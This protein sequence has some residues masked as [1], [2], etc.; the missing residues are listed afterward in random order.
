MLGAP[1][2]L[3]C[4]GRTDAGVHGWGQ[5]VSFDA[6]ADRFD[7]EK[8]QHAVNGLCGPAI[9]VRS[10]EVAEPGFSARFDAKAR[11]Y[12]YTIL[13]RPVP[14]WVAVRW[15]RFQQRYEFTAVPFDTANQVFAVEQEVVNA[16]KLAPLDG[17]DGTV[18]FRL[19]VPIPGMPDQGF[20]SMSVEIEDA[21]NITE[22]AGQLQAALVEE[23]GLDENGNPV[24]I[25]E[26]P[27]GILR[28][29]AKVQGFEL[30]PSQALFLDELAIAG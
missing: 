23:F 28:L 1:I 20:V 4:A 26:F 29:R 24:V 9:V 27:D 19:R 18:N 15:D 8:V 25:V 12:R 13:N 6:P 16:T 22:L 2:E 17:F 7:A 10:V 14:D 3:T 11:R 21:G 5:V 30:Y